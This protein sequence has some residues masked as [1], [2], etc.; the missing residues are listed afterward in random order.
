M[1][2]TR[3]LEYRD[4]VLKATACFVGRAEPPNDVIWWE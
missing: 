4:G 2:M 1:Q 3:R